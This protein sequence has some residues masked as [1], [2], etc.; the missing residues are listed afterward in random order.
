MV[1]AGSAAQ[2]MCCAPA[3]QIWPQ[4]STVEL[5]GANV[6][7]WDRA[8]RVLPPQMELGRKYL[9]IT[10][11]SHLAGFAKPCLGNINTFLRFR[12]FVSVLPS[13]SIH[14]CS[15]DLK[16]GE[17]GLPVVLPVFSPLAARQGL[18]CLSS[19][20]EKKTA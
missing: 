15:L 11:L 14:K 6:S 18:M 10:C 7:S 3:G 2:H 19:F 17:Q 4:S 1:L 20:T 8:S 9:K 5:A 12:V 16:D 13:I